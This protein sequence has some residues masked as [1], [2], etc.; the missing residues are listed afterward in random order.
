MIRFG[1]VRQLPISDRQQT[2]RC[3]DFRF[4]C[5][6]KFLFQ[7]VIPLA[8]Y[9][10]EFAAIAVDEPM[11][12]Q[13]ERMKGNAV[14]LFNESILKSQLGSFAKASYVFTA[15]ESDIIL[16]HRATEVGIRAEFHAAEVGNCAER[17][18]VELDD[19]VERR[20]EEVGSL[21]ERRVAEVS[22]R[23]ERHAAEVG[24]CAERR[25]VELDDSA[26]RRS[27]EVGSPPEH[28]VDEFGIRAKSRSK[29][30]GRSIERRVAELGNFAEHRAAEVGTRAK[31]CV[32]EMGT[33][34][35][36]RVAEVGTRAKRRA[37]E[38]GNCAERRATEVGLHAKRRTKEVCVRLEFCFYEVCICAELEIS[39][40]YIFRKP[41]AT[42]VVIFTFQFSIEGNAKSFHFVSTGIMQHTVPLAFV[43][44]EERFALAG[45]TRPFSAITDEC[46]RNIRR[47]GLGLGC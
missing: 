37:P 23:A 28:H 35:K 20:A 4:G 29:E 12:F 45:R 41:H 24:N 19:S 27:V 39:K 21:A 26:E 11:W 44:P 40:T 6:F 16:E 25:S 5:A 7:I 42:K 34:A 15:N 8:V 10:L 17:R 9:E 47:S 36:S 38:I 1:I 32:V 18:S 13:V 30:V 33:C 2:M 43:F 3:G 46:R 14:G 22:I 31:R